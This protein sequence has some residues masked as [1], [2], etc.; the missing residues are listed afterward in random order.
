MSDGLLNSKIQRIQEIGN[1]I[2]AV[3]FDDD[4]KKLSGI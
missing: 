4:T 2:K 3:L 1:G